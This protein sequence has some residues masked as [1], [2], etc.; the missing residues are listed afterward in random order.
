MCGDGVVMCGVVSL[1]SSVVLCRAL[2][3]AVSCT[4]D[5]AVRATVV[6]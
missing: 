6:H 1:G 4:C 5:V 2:C 3:C